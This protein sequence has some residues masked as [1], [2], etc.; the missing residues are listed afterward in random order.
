[1]GHFGANVKSASEKKWKIHRE[2][3][4]SRWIVLLLCYRNTI[5]THSENRREFMMDLNQIIESQAGLL[6]ALQELAAGKID[7]AAY[8]PFGA[9]FGVYPQ[10]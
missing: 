3:G 1:M 2:T 5:L 10:R 8:K 6:N 7:F 4:Y 9:P